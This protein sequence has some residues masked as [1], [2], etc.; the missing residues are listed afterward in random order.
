[1]DTV[2]ITRIT[3]TVLNARTADQMEAEGF[4]R[5]AQVM[6]QNNIKLDLNLKRPNG[7]KLFHAVQ[8]TNGVYSVPVKI[9]L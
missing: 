4:P 9:G 7:Q 5:V 1:M 2:T 6:R 8:W 3:Y